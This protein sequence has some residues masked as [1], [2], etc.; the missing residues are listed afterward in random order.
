MITRF[1]QGPMPPPQGGYYRTE[2]LSDVGY[3]VEWMM[4][5]AKSYNQGRNTDDWTA[6]ATQL[7]D[8]DG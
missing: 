8:L 4:L 1:V 5:S 2:T 6:R 3:G 7:S